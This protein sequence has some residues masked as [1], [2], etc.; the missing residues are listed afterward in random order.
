MESQQWVNNVLARVHMLSRPNSL[1]HEQVM[2]GHTIN[3]RYG[4]VSRRCTIALEHEQGIRGHAS[5]SKG[6]SVEDSTSYLSPGFHS[7]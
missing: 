6:S 3:L 4:H 1:M 7:V 5:S 2:R